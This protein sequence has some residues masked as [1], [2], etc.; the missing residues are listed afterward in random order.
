[1]QKEKARVESSLGALVYS[2]TDG[3]DLD[4]KKTVLFLAAALRLENVTGFFEEN[5]VKRGIPIRHTTVTHDRFFPMVLIRASLRSELVDDLKLRQD[6]TCRTHFVAF[7]F[8]VSICSHS[9][10]IIFAYIRM[11][12]ISH[13]ADLGTRYC[14]LTYMHHV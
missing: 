8:A 14:T 1:M 10:C 9:F 4:R 3:K 7:L 11:T 13:V 2:S 6:A 5:S 12:F